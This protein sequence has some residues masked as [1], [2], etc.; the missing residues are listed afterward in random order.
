MEKLQ[1]I[2]VELGKNSYPIYIDAG[3]LSELGGVLQRHLP[4]HK[5]MLVT[6]HVIGDLYGGII[7]D[8]LRSA[9]IEV[10]TK[11]VPDGE[12]F[13][14]LTW[15]G[16]LIDAFIDYQMTRYSGV[17][18]LGG[19]VIGDLAGFAAAT[20][21]R[22]IPYVQVPTSLIA[23]VDSS[24]GGKTAVNHPKGKNLIGA[25]HQPKLVLIDVNVLKSLPERE[26]RS[27]LAE[28]IKHAVIMDE[29]LFGYME[30]S[31]S[32]ILNLDIQSIE[33]IVARSCKDKATVIEKDEREH[34]LRAI[35]NYGH[36]VGHSIETVSGYEIFRHGEAVSIGMVVAARIAA[37]MGML[38]KK[39]ESRQNELLKAA[40]LPVKFPSSLD[41]E[42]VIATMY[43]D[44]KIREAHRLRFI[45]PKTI[46]KAMVVEDI[47]DSQIRQA[48]QEVMD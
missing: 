33:Q 43:L 35:L 14:S 25:F 13:K 16:K 32:K 22:G 29:E 40:G 10:S 1:Q 12:E 34:S 42:K 47:T 24:V 36:T 48:I 21:M 38:D 44:K 5:V 20:F 19:G 45:L 26:L 8:S 6:N 39:S 17:I 23:Q 2:H 3:C 18:A 4:L 7:R 46:G 31:I 28:V 41:I 15:A 30:S 11:E 37:N 9:E 27:G